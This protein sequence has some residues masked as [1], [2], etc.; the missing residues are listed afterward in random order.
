MVGTVPQFPSAG[1]A[2]PPFPFRSLDPT[3]PPTH[4]LDQLIWAVQGLAEVIDP[5]LALAG[6]DHGPGATRLRLLIAHQDTLVGALLR[7]RAT[8]LAELRQARAGQEGQPPRTETARC[9]G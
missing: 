2:S 3:G 4:R 9:R 7:E 6:E 1:N 5:D 8:L